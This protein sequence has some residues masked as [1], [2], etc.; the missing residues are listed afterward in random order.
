MIYHILA[1]GDVVGE[2]GIRHL[3]R[4]LRSIKQQKNMLK[5][6]KLRPKE[7]AIRKR[8][9]GRDDKVTRQKMQEDLMKL[10]Q[11]ERHG[12]GDGLDGKQLYV[13]HVPPDP[14]MAGAWIPCGCRCGV[15]DNGR[16][17]EDWT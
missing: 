11:D 12:K 7:Q 8:Y 1:V 6:A 10:Y 5:Q 17:E 2:A 4:H 14:E 9:A 13:R 15:P 3:Q 16:G